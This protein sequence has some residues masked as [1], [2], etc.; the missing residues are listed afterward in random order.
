MSNVYTISVPTTH[1]CDSVSVPYYPRPAP[2]P[3]ASD[4]AARRAAQRAGYIARKSRGRESLDNFGGF[5][6]IDPA[7]S[8]VAAGF[9]FDLSARDVID[10]CRS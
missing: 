8:V 7:T 1:T 4:S 3:G 10:W 2:E 5:M 6:I 9:R